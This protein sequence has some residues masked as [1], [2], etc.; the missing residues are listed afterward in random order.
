MRVNSLSISCTETPGQ[1]L[2]FLV[3]LWGSMA[4][5]L[6]VP[7]LFMISAYVA[8]IKPMKTLPFII[9]LNAL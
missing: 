7:D 5:R 3:S 6:R 1:L 8:N 2:L 9:E 4:R